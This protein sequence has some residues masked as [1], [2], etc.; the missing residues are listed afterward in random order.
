MPALGTSLILIAIGALLA[1]A[2]APAAEGP[3]VA[4]VGV[5]LMGV[6]FVG[7][8]VALLFLLSFSP[9]ASRDYIDTPGRRRHF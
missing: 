9:F 1:F 4:T 3:L 6:G 2:V 5:V 8:L 7:V